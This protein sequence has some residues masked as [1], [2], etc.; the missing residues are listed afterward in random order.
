MSLFKDEIGSVDSVE[1]LDDLEIKRDDKE[2]DKTVWSRF[3]DLLK[4]TRLDDGKID[5]WF[6][7]IDIM[8]AFSVAMS[9][10]MVPISLWIALVGLGM[11]FSFLTAFAGVV[12][13]Q[14]AVTGLLCFVPGILLALFILY[15]PREFFK[16]GF[17][18]RALIFGALAAAGLVLFIHFGFIAIPSLTLLGA[19]SMAFNVAFL[20]SF[21]L[22][23]VLRNVGIAKKS[24]SLR[25]SVMFYLFGLVTLA[26]LIVAAGFGMPVVLPFL[27]S[28]VL[29]IGLSAVIISAVCFLPA[30]LFQA[31]S[32]EKGFY[33]PVVYLWK[34]AFNDIPGTFYVMMVV[35]TAIVL[36]LLPMVHISVPVLLTG[37]L[38]LGVGVPLASR[39]SSG[40]FV[41]FLRVASFGR[42]KEIVHKARKENNFFAR[43]FL[44]VLN[45]L[46]GDNYRATKKIT[47]N[48]PNDL[49]DDCAQEQEC[50]IT[51][52]MKFQSGSVQQ[53]LAT[54][55]GWIGFFMP[56]PMH[57]E[58][59]GEYDRE[60]TVEFEYSD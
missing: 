55:K 16:Q 18:Y 5:Y 42:S 51:Y 36:G 35:T 45:T 13:L 33:G 41:A 20:L 53:M 21:G 30:M 50:T 7:A 12:G 54:G 26:G 48:F 32:S 6:W 57:Q 15:G 2:K 44:F 22:D 3:Y 58:E 38:A 39:Y 49:P 40:L 59:Q 52:T 43:A 14:I 10:I 27:G 37:A 23:G 4:P 11:Y 46:H 9:A 24:Q 47:D 31:V 8:R 25:T 1:S 19:V 28:G 17:I 60:E 34:L 56:L 29:A